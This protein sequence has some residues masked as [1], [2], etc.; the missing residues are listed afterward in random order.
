MENDENPW[1]GMGCSPIFSDKPM[2]PLFFKRT[3]DE[4]D[5][6]HSVFSEYSVVQVQ[7]V[8]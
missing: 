3:W 7:Q 4:W 2:Y 5:D 8:A 6:E 1:D